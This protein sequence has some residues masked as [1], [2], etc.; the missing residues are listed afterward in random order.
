MR[1]T[2]SRQVKYKPPASRELSR[3]NLASQKGSVVNLHCD[4]TL[5]RVSVVLH[6]HVLVCERRKL[7]Y[8]DGARAAGA[9]STGA[10]AEER[11]PRGRAGSRSSRGSLLDDSR[12][13]DGA[14][15][16]PGGQSAGSRSSQPRP[17]SSGGRSG[18]S[19]G[20]TGLHNSTSMVAGGSSSSSSLGTGDGEVD[21][22][23]ADPGGAG[24]Y[25]GALGF[26]AALFDNASELLDEDLYLKSQWKYAFIHLPRLPL[27]TP[28]RMERVIRAPEVP[29]VERIYSFIR[30]LFVEAELSSECCVVCLVYVERLMERASV[31]LLAINWRP[32]VMAGMLLASKVWQDLSS[33]NIEFARVYPQFSVQ[34]INRLERNILRL[35]QWDLFISGAVYAKYYFALRSLNESKNFRQRYNYIMR[36]QNAPQARQLE[37]R[38]AHASNLLYSRSL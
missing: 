8:D 15:Q 23:A 30:H 34:S 36:P 13:S 26:D 16:S 33:W 6:R 3:E 29:T 11:A 2:D 7:L 31:E 5:R 32:I 22:G 21:G 14:T 35:L 9:G 10:V 27:W 17:R 25:R 19:R 18:Q 24:G 38:S 12:A 37:K 1:N 28:Y 4:D 20:A